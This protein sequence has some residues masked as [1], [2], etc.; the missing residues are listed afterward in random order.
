MKCSRL[1][2]ASALAV[3]FLAGT[4]ARADFIDWSYNWER[5]PVS[6]A[7]GGAGTGGVSFTDEPTKMATG[8]SD[9]VATNV[10][11]FSSAT[12]AN[13]DVL[14]A[15]SNYTLSLTLT[16]KASGATGTLNFG[17]TLSGT[18]SASNA[19]VGNTFTG[20][21]SQTLT[22]GNNTYTV[23]IGPYS[24]PGPPSASNA[25]SIA[26]HVD[27]NGGTIGNTQTPE[28]TTMVLGCLGL[29][30]LGAAGWRK[31]KAAVPA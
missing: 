27:V 14:P 30:F 28:P 15:G 31:R 13:P 18:F 21:L 17:G 29:S 5:N 12:A 24:P 25:G 22:L 7:S 23:T 26:A 10:R 9:V 1:L 6:V 11:V 4:S 16:D 3:L 2:F 20:P 8:N 19:N